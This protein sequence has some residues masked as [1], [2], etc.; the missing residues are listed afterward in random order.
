MPVAELAIRLGLAGLIG[1]A[2]GTEREWSG[3]ATGPRARFAGARTFFLLGLLGGISGWLVGTAARPLAIVLIAGGAALAI[4]AYAAATLVTHDADGT[5][6]TAAL[7]VL[8]TGALAGLGRGA[9]AS[10]IAAVAVAAL[11][12]KVRIQR[13]VQRIEEKELRAAFH[14]AVLALVVLPLLPEGPFGTWGGG[15]RPRALWLLVLVFA[16][17]SFAGYVARSAVSPRY[18]T[19]LTGLIGG[20]ISSTGVTLTFAR[21]SRTHPEEGRPLAHGVLAAC[22]VL[23]PRV[24]AAVA[25]LAPAVVPALAL[26]LGPAFVVGAIAASMGLRRGV[27]AA[28]PASHARNPL[29][30]GA[31]L[32]MAALFQ[33]VLI[34]LH[35][36]RARFGGAGV[37]WSAVL[38]GLTD[39]DALTASIAAQTRTGLAVESAA[40]AIAVGVVAN[41]GLKIGIAVAIGRG[42]F[43]WRVAAGLAAVAAATMAALHVAG[44]LG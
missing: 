37:Q 16:G 13:L 20:L 21:A 33:V 6:E 4:V 11:A 15:V 40:N 2:V 34:V 10:G 25:L 7:L 3:H 14:F 17:L 9:I 41:T 23:V 43:R 28:P 30:L 26:R 35:E 8:A 24:L 18:G 19:V 42:T 32:Q 27:E 39:V 38:L 29:Q 22:T 44:A 1:L 12:E 36:V 5:T 31:A